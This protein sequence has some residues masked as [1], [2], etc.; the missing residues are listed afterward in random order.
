MDAVGELDHDDAD[1]LDHG[2]HHFAEA[3]GLA[4]LGGGEIQL[5]ELGDA[6]DAAGD[7]LAE[8]LANLIDG[9]AGVLDHVVEEAGFHGDE[10]H[11]HVGKDVG[12][13]DGVE[14]VRLPRVAG[15]A[16]VA[17]AGEVEGLFEGGE[18]VV[19][20]ILADFGFEFAI[21]AVHGIYGKDIGRG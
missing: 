2:Q 9:D 17:V 5:G 16:F 1:I 3:L 21:D 8:L 4:L 15:L 10:V 7:L 20:A 12:N 13:H 19:G 11:A 14:H 18:V 6:I